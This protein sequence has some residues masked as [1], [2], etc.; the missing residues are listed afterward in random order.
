[1]PRLTCRVHRLVIKSAY[2]TAQQA[3]PIAQLFECAA[4]TT[5]WQLL[6]SIFL[7]GH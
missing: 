4:V 2:P 7:E 3:T 5:V 1:M 6:E